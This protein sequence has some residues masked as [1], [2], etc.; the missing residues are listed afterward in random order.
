MKTPVNVR[1]LKRVEERINRVPNEELPEN[2]DPTQIFDPLIDADELPEECF[3]NEEAQPTVNDEENKENDEEQIQTANKNNKE[4]A[5]EEIEKEE[6]EYYMVEK[7]LKGRYRKGQTEPEYYLKWENYETPTW[8]PLMAQAQLKGPIFKEAS[9]QTDVKQE[10]TPGKRAPE[11]DNM[12]LKNLLR[13]G[14][15]LQIRRMCMH[16][17]P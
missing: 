17:I 12:R 13:R 8:E 10:A 16:T 2:Y 14:Q 6:D 1:R 9:T 7:V 11:V 5:P 15:L 3:D 4:Q